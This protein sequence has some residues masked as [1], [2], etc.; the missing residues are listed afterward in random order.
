MSVQFTVLDAETN[1]PIWGAVVLINNYQGVGWM[2]AQNGRTNQIG[3]ESNWILAITATTVDVEVYHHWGG[4]IPFIQMQMPIL[5][6]EENNITILLNRDPASLRQRT[7]IAPSSDLTCPLTIKVMETGTYP[8]TVIPGATVSAYMVV[9]T[10]TLTTDSKGEVTYES[11][12]IPLSTT[13]RLRVTAP[14]YQSFE[15]MNG[16]PALFTGP[17]LEVRLTPEPVVPPPPPPEPPPEPVSLICPSCGATIT[18]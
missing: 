9:G 16:P 15:I 17:F 12:G 8:G 2:T 5:P 6:G 11:F 10:N 14:G 3:D 7:I 13:Y 18:V 1:Q 4:Y